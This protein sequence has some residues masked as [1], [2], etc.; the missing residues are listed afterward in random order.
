MA[1]RLHLSDGKGQK[2]GQRVQPPP[3]NGSGPAV[4]RNVDFIISPPS[5][6]R[7]QFHVTVDGLR[8]CSFEADDVHPFFGELREWMERCLS[9]DTKG[10]FHPEVVTLEMSGDVFHFF[11]QHRGWLP[12]RGDPVPYA[13]F[14]IF[15]SGDVTPLLRQG[16]DHLRTIA[17][18][19]S[20]LR[21]CLEE[22]RSLFDDPG[23]WYDVKYFKPEGGGSTV[24]RLMADLRSPLIEKNIR[25][26]MHF[27]RG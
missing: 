17:N 5:R 24:D 23:N 14:S 7:I 4:L 18:L 13:V 21:R 3:G 11:L 26:V 9:L 20:A 22:N 12:G 2:A 15:R 16:C 25:F 19:Y 1:S 6:G 10:R 8:M 27:I